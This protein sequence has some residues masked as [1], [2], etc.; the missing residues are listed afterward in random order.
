MPLVVRCILVPCCFRQQPLQCWFRPQEDQTVQNWALPCQW[1]AGIETQRLIEAVQNAGETNGNAATQSA[2]MRSP[3]FGIPFLFLSRL[4][5]LYPDP[6][7]SCIA[8]GRVGVLALGRAPR[9]RADHP[10][11]NCHLVDLCVPGL[12]HRISYVRSHYLVAVHHNPVHVSQGVWHRRCIGSC[13]VVVSET[14][15]AWLSE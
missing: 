13:F 6:F 3:R 10:F 8:L 1:E 15:E 9:I 12:R 14:H 7:S 5:S 11:V 2:G 4:V